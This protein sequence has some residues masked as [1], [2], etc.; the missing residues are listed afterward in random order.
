[1]RVLVNNWL[2]LSEYAGDA[3][4]KNPKTNEMVY[5]LYGRGFSGVVRFDF[6]VVIYAFLHSD[7]C[8][9]HFIWPDVRA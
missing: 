8:Q 4:G 5:H 2:W 7:V 6:S 1:M 3:P 9:P